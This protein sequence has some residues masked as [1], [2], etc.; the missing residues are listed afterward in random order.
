[1]CIYENFQDNRYNNTSTGLIQEKNVNG[2]TN[3]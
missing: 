2:T 3:K 1:M